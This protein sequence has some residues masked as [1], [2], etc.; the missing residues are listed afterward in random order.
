MIFSD[1][2]SL[3]AARPEATYPAEG[4]FSLTVI[5][6]FKNSRTGAEAA[7][8]LG[9]SHR[10]ESLSEVRCSAR[11]TQ[12]ANSVGSD[13]ITVCLMIHA[14]GGGGIS[15]HCWGAFESKNKMIVPHEN[16][17]ESQLLKY[18]E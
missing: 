13:R 8:G 7:G 17:C 6:S 12:R 15:P 1:W 3:K 4:N 11:L 16:H 10:V 2:M 9:T 14:K 18:T 5:M